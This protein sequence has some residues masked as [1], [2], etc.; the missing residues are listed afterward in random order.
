[1]ISIYADKRICLICP[2][3]NKSEGIYEDTFQLNWHNIPLQNLESDLI[4][5]SKLLLSN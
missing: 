2:F 3:S 1:M 5:I 4:H